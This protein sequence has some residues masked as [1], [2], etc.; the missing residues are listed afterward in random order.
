MTSDPGQGDPWIMFAQLFDRWAPDHHAQPATAVEL[1][2]PQSDDQKEVR[3][4]D[5]RTVTKEAVKQFA[6]RSTKESAR[7]ERRAVPV[8]HLRSEHVKRFLAERRQRI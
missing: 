8:G 7:L 3:T 4:V 5:G 1:L 6:A 2:W